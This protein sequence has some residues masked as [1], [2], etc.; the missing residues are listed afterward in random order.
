MGDASEKVLRLRRDDTCRVCAAPLAAGVTA[1]YECAGRTVRCLT[2][3]AEDAVVDPGTAGASARREHERRR[4]RRERRV[5]EKHPRIGGFLLAV[6]DDPA[7]TRSWETGAAGE[8]RLGVRLDGIAS[9]AVR[10]LHDRRIP[11]SRAN[12]D[13]LV[14]T[15]GGVWVVD[16]KRYAGRPTLRI[17]GGLLRPRVEKLVVAGRDRTKLVD[18]VLRQVEVVTDVLGDATPVRGALCFVEADWPLIG[19]AFTTRGVEVLWPKKLAATVTAPAAAVL[20]VAAVHQRLAI[21][22]RPA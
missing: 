21:A 1:T 3:P 19:G 5:R 6:T 8:E 15:A 14:V 13:H 22:L 16:A 17:E 11:G 9:E 10:V 12:I 4:D 2:C 7:S 18:G 20:D